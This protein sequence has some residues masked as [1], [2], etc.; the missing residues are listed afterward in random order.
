[1]KWE[2]Y[3][4]LVEFW[5]VFIFLFCGGIICVWNNIITTVLFIDPF[6]HYVSI[7]TDYCTMRMFDTGRSDWSLCFVQSTDS[8][9]FEEICCNV[10]TSKNIYIFSFLQICKISTE[11]ETNIYE[12]CLFLCSM[13]FQCY[14]T[15]NQNK[16]E[17]SD[18]KGK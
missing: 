4:S 6:L 11:V 15:K 3:V 1:M 8:Q 2:W 10:T 12:L 18:M 7:R 9:L 14:S 17:W 5:F 13:F 16:C